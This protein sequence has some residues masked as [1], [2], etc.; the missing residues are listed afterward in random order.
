MKAI[1]LIAAIATTSFMYA[2]VKV[3]EENVSFSNGS[4]NAIVVTIPHG[5]KE[6]VDK[7]LK[8]E[9][10]DWGGKYSSSKGEMTTVQSSV[11]S[12][13]D[14]PFDG[15]ARILDGGSDYVKVA[16]AVDLGGAYLDSKQHGA[17]FS[18][19]KQ[20]AEKF[21]SRTS[22]LSIEEELATEAKV[23]KTMEKEKVELEKTITNSKKDIEE[24]QKR[25]AEAEQKIKDSEAGL[26]KKSEEI[27]A[28]TTRIGDVEKKK[29]SVN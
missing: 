26:A 17:Q 25:I 5:N 6:V 11:K 19:M 10:K 16:F 29:K 15:Y 23:L 3:T 20:R 22:V 24:Y 27:T 18:A 28:Q 4:H 2:Q 1:T 7:E 13:G 21:A 12:M 14:K 8:S 9:L